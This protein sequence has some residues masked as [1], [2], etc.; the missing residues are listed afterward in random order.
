MR[1]RFGLSLPGY[2][3]ASPASTDTFGQLLKECLCLLDLFMCSYGQVLTDSVA[4]HRSA[5]IL[6]LMSDS[7]VSFPSFATF[8]TS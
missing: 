7:S 6:R 4:E 1:R 5:A 2:H 3:R 8:N